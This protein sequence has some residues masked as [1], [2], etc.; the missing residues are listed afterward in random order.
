[1]V[2]EGG[3]GSAQDYPVSESGAT[4][5][6]TQVVMAEIEAEGSLSFPKYHELALYEPRDGYYSRSD[7]ARTG[8]AGDFFTAVSVG[9]L[10]GRIL[11]QY[12]A[13]LWE[14]LA[15]PAD[16]RV[17]EWG[18]EQG[19][20]ARDIQQG[21]IE[22]G[23]A[24][25]AAFR[26]AIVEP[27]PQKREMLVSTLPGVEVVARAGD[28]AP[29]AGLVLGNELIDALSFW[30]VRYESGRWREKRVVKGGS[31]GTFTYQNQEP[32]PQ[33]AE[34]LAI[35]APFQNSF[36][37]G[38]ETEIRPSLA[39]LLREMRGVLTRGEILLLDYGYER[40]DYYHPARTT[41]T[42]RTYGKHR[43]A[44]DP[45]VEIGELDITAHVDFTSLAEDGTA[46]G[47]TAQP[48]QSQGSFLTKAAAQWLR[49][50]DGRV[51][52]TMI[53]QFQTLTHPAH[54]GTKFWVVAFDVD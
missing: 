13:Q 9:P 42:I 50:Q 27:I 34:R 4:A 28:L 22:I 51:D 45:L 17:V 10:F 32:S 46:I 19:D 30:L 38:Y 16:F 21:V 5:R 39:P 20:L 7:K 33:L 49:S 8:R 48:L 53:R 1:M 23:G 25:A 52:P 43:A 26:Y 18:A 15:Q 47:L 35:I 40:P 2:A 41:G 36:E 37:E 11:A 54:L 12:A 14:K 29:L 44:E 31:A 24:F 6:L 3:A